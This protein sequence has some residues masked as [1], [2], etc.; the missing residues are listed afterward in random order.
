MPNVKISR[1]ISE[2]L[3]LEL[4]FVLRHLAEKLKF[5]G[6]EFVLTKM[7]EWNTP[8][9]GSSIFI[10]GFGDFDSSEQMK[11]DQLAKTIRN[12]FAIPVFPVAS[13]CFSIGEVEKSSPYFQIM[14][15]P[16][17]DYLGLIKKLH[18]GYDVELHLINSNIHPDDLEDG[19]VEIILT[20]NEAKLFG[21]IISEF[22]ST[23]FPKELLW[24]KI[25]TRFVPGNQLA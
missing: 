15:G 25:I 4:K 1:G 10:Y 23:S 7:E 13:S 8:F 22:E 12:N 17:D 11:R 24:P 18:L 20:P 19:Y 21:G 3:F 6:V 5:K 2:E 14:C 16:K 9:S